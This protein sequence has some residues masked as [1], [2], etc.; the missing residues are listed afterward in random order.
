MKGV[1]VEPGCFLSLVASAVEAYNR[2]TNGF[3]LGSNGG[4]GRGIQGNGN[5]ILQAAYPLQTE[6]RKPNSVTHG[7]QQAFE[8]ARRT[9]RNLYVGLD[10]LGGYHSH[11]GIDGAA[12]LSRDDLEYIGGELSGLISRNGSKEVNWL[13][14][15]LATRQR[16][17]SR[18][19][20][21]AWSWR[22][23]PKKI[24]FTIAIKPSLGYDMTV[25]AYWVRGEFNS[26][27]LKKLETEEAKVLI[28]WSR[29][30]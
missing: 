14:V 13:E 1:V 9:V 26:N 23:Y 22:R 7:N 5:A 18:A 10:L 28:P 8:R 12:D 25:A 17:Y 11:T 15:V 3:V 16:E 29:K 21:V 27:G 20:K 2:E 4:T 19:H 6:E 24:G 30:L